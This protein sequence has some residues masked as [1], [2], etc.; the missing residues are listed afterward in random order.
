MPLTD[1][2]I[3]QVKHSGKPGGH[4]YSDG[5]GMY[6]LV[7]AAGNYW[8]MDYRFAEKRKTLALGVYP[9]V[10]LA[11]AR[12]RRQEARELLAEGIDPGVA[13]KAQEAQEAAETANTVKAVGDAWLATKK[14]GW[15]DVH[16]ER[17]SRN[18]EKD[19]Y[20][21]LG[22]RPIGQIEPPE[23]LKVVR[24]V[25]ERGALDVA[26]RVLLTSR[27]VWQHAVAEGYA[28][29]DITQDIKKALQTHT[30]KNYPAITNPIEL[31]KLLRACDG[32]KGGPVV[33]AALAIV[34]V[35]FQ[36]PGNIRAMRWADLD[37]DG[38]IWAIPSAD[39]K[40]TKAQK[41]NG[42]EHLVPLPRQ[43]V[44][45]LRELQPLTGN[46]EFVFPGLRDPKAPMSEAAVS[47]ALNAMGYKDIQT[48]HGFR[49][50][51]RTI[52]REQL[53]Y[54]KDVIEY[55]LAH[56]GQITHGGAY[57]RAEF[58][59]ER[60]EMLQAWADYLDKLRQGPEMLL[61]QKR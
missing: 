9:E 29:R 23:L 61:L 5:E 16:Y 60:R 41:L 45:V 57:D 19:V 32:Y 7:K 58:L 35:L 6:L 8:R 47:A 34:P 31:G 4:K 42:A 50:T 14:G 20:P 37:L 51:G 21:F 36:R 53:R 39:M 55:Q 38:G 30:K 25:E 44:E 10:S 33:R 48:W 59:D 56:K 43:V 13:K 3:R 24:R 15:S 28:Q 27:G 1:T 40:R 11:K 54:P 52:I 26:H 17:E 12:K 49:A 2:F 18:L 46:R 22:T